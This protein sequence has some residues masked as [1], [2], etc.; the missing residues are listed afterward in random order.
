[1]M[2]GRLRGG[3]MVVGVVACWLACMAPA[4]AALF[5]ELLKS[6]DGFVA[7]RAAPDANAKLVARMRAG[8]EVQ[9]LEGRKG[10]WQE[11]RHWR[12]VIGLQT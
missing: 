1:M 2:R 12:R 3:F 7:L 9:A 10:R 6:A 4:N 11:V 8:D 5:C